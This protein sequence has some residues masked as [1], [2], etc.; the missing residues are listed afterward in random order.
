M[1]QFVLISDRPLDL[2]WAQARGLVAVSEP[3]QTVPETVTN[4][5]VD[6][7]CWRLKENRKPNE[8][9]G[10]C[11]WRLVVHRLISVRSVVQIYPG[12]LPGSPCPIWRYAGRGFGYYASAAHLLAAVALNWTPF[13]P[14]FGSSPPTCLGAAPTE[15]PRSLRCRSGRRRRSRA[16]CRVAEGK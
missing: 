16:A 4:S 14:C 7:G 15:H 12:P 2:A 6:D 8:M 10:F 3:P 1:P 13:R 5:T 9:G 11:C